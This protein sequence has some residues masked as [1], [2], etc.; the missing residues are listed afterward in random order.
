VNSVCIV[1]HGPSLVGAAKGPNIDKHIVVRLKWGEHLLKEPLDYGIKTDYVCASTE[2]PQAFQTVEAKEYW[3]YP[4]KGFY[5]E[6][7]IQAV[8]RPILV[9]LNLCNTWNAWFRSMGGKHPN[10]STGTGALIIACHRLRPKKVLLAGF[11]TLMNPEIR[12]SRNKKVPRS[13]TGPYPNHDWKKENELLELI[14][15]AYDVEIEVL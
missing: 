7:R 6:S 4:K 8:G 14:K 11:D 15:D 2:I 9:P 3:G 1:G 10:V 5:N 12:F 13:G